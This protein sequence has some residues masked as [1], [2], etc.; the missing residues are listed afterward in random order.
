MNAWTPS[1]IQQCTTSYSS[2]LYNHFI[3]YQ[4]N[5]SSLHYKT[6][7]FNHIIIQSLHYIIMSNYYIILTSL[8]TLPT[9]SAIFL[10]ISATY[11][12]NLAT[13]PNFATN[14]AT[15]HVNSAKAFQSSIITLNGYWSDILYEQ[16]IYNRFLKS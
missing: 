9:K 1:K 2:S 8:N 13:L 12:T 3:I 7:S 11:N 16:S 10:T 15:C 4:I 6:S 14:S 5:I